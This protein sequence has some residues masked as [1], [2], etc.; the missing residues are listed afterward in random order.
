LRYAGDKDKSL[1]AILGD[2]ANT[3]VTTFLI[4]DRIW[5]P[6]STRRAFY[7][8]T[9]VLKIANNVIPF[10]HELPKEV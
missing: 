9:I 3:E 6:P 1:D 10:V 2:P 5:K 7:V 8:L 4:S